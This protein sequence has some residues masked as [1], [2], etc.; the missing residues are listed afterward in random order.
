MLIGPRQC[1]KTWLG[2]RLL[3]ASAGPVLD[4]ALDDT[5]TRTLAGREPAVVLGPGLRPTLID[6][7]QEAPGLLSE[8]K[9]RIDAA[10]RADRSIPPVWV[11]GSNATQLD[12]AA[13]E[14]LS[15][16]ANYYRLHN[17]SAAELDRA[18]IGP[19]ELFT[20]GG[21][22][23]LYANRALDP[24][25]YLDDHVR[26]FIE[27]DIAATAGVAKLGAFRT[28]LGL[29]AA[30]TGQLLNA[31]DIGRQ[32]GVKGA[33]VA[34]W[35]ALLEEN[36]VVALVRPHATNL[37]ARLV[38]APKVY[39]LDVGVAARLQGWRTLEPLLVSPQIG[40]LFET[41]VFAELVRCRDHRLLGME[42]HVWRTRDGEELDFLVR[43][44]TVR[45][46]PVWVPIEAKLGGH[47]ALGAVV[48]RGVARA[49]APLDPLLVVTLEGHRRALAGNA[50]QV[51]LPRLADELTALAND[52]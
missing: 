21:W 11:T 39:L 29:L 13:K 33:T 7:I 49:V 36:A 24:V 51:P 26:T 35:I 25:R 16:R 12:R 2:H 52:S 37:N 41:A 48:P 23:E 8:L 5:Q 1:G 17:L 22:P 38:K 15:G 18:G 50:I 19:R 27:K 30:R 28:F 43:L 14:S 9:L 46:G 34:E 45:R 10:C 6:E 40:P 3:R 32:A 42:I 47:A 44:E 20:R 4:I 31:S